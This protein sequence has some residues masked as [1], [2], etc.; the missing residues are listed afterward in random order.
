MNQSTGGGFSSPLGGIL[1]SA[2]AAAL[3]SPSALQYG[4]TAGAP[5]L[6][7]VVHARESAALGRD[8]GAVVVTHGSQ[9]AL[10]LLAQ[11][12]LDPGDVVVVEEIED[13]DGQP[14]GRSASDAHTEA[15]PM[16]GQGMTDEDEDVDAASADDLQ[17]VDA[18]AG[19]VKGTPAS[20]YGQLRLLSVPRNTTV[21]GVGQ[22]QNDIVSSNATSGDGS[23]TLTDYLNNANRGGSQVSYGNQLALPVGEGFL[24]V[25]P[26][27]LSSASG[28]SYPQL[29]IV[30]VTFGGKVAWAQDLETALDELFGG[31]AG[32]TAEGKPSGEP[33]KKPKEDIK[34]VF[35]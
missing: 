31:D 19:S 10:S 14:V 25:E 29:R 26:I 22:V 2:A 16:V 30:I 21:P 7:D 24:H 20:D 33:T 27:Y 15:I 5:T 11:A 8:A 1:G 23:Q 32:V 35:M 3:R 13:V 28:T 12:L 9:Q 34:T 6:R 17:P 18:D 4:L